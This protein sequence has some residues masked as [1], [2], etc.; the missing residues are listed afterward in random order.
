MKTIYTSLVILSIFTLAYTPSFAQRVNPLFSKSIIHRKASMGFEYGFGVASIQLNEINQRLEE[1]QIGQLTNLQA[2]IPLHLYFEGANG[3]GVSFDVHAS[4]S[5]QNEVYKRNTNLDFYTMGFGATVHIP[6]IYSN[7]VGVWATGGIRSNSM[8]FQYNYN[9]NSSA[10]FANLLT[11]PATDNHSI[12]LISSANEMAAFGGK[13]QYRFWRKDKMKNHEIRVGVN[14]E[15][16]YPL[17]QGPWRERSSKAVITDMPN[18]NPKN[19]SFNLTLT[20]LLTLK[21]H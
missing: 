2:N 11:N 1:L 6:I 19:L 13:F 15:Y 5:P 18:I 12:N 20:L 9:T 17:S 21:E 16:N 14:S 4:I 10:N 3:L 7:R 8:Y